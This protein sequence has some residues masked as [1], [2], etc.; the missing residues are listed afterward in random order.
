MSG[1]EE[2]QSTLP[3]AHIVRSIS[4]D[5]DAQKGQSDIDNGNEMMKEPDEKVEENLNINRYLLAKSSLSA[6]DADIMDSEI[7]SIA[8]K[9]GIAFGHNSS[10]NDVNENEERSSDGTA[11]S[12]RFSNDSETAALSPSFPLIR[13][14]EESEMPTTEE[15]VGPD[16]YEDLSIEQ[17]AFTKHSSL[18]VENTLDC[19]TIEPKI[20]EESSNLLEQVDMIRKEAAY[21]GDR[22]KFS[23]ESDCVSQI[24]E[25]NKDTEGVSCKENIVSSSVDRNNDV[26]NEKE[27]EPLAADIW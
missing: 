3:E 23:N 14:K 27:S 5:R 22:K 1:T 17:N 6:T 4:C 12:G 24:Y 9:E 11:F 21:N 13:D 10:C 2:C 20:E 16:I 7:S 26:C 8:S 19:S 18:V 25:E 15:E